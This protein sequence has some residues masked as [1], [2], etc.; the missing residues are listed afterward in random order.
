PT[1]P[2]YAFPTRRSSDLDLDRL[3]AE[4][5]N[6]FGGLDLLI[7]NAA[8]G[9]NR[10]VMEQRVKGWDW[11]MSINARAALFAAQRAAPIMQQRGGGA[12]RKSTRLNS[13]HEWIS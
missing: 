7:N 2:L 10:P 3:F 1:R 5:K 6:T 13:S 12:D 4:I 9:Y 11:T 8:S